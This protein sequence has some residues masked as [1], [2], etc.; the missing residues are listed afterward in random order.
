M[1]ADKR[2]WHGTQRKTDQLD[3]GPTDI[4]SNAIA[5]G[6]WQDC[7]DYDDISPVGVIEANAGDEV[8]MQWD[9]HWPQGHPGVSCM[10]SI[11][12]MDSS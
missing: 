4:F 9:E 8:V 3:L 6:G 5:T 7:W 2:T 1:Q 11:M 10:P 12:S